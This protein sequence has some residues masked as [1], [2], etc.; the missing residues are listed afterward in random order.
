MIRVVVVDDEAVRRVEVARLGTAFAPCLD[1]VAV[2]VEL[3][4]TGV[5]VAVGDEHAAVSG[6]ADVGFLIEVRPAGNRAL[7]E[8]G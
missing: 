3:R 2:L 4:H 5:A 8:L 6:P 7:D 1:E